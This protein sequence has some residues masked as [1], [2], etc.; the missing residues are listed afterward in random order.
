MVKERK[1]SVSMCVYGKD[2]PIWF[3]TAVESILNQTMKPAEVVLVV[4]G[5]VPNALDVVI[6]KYETSSLFK[7]VRFAENKGHGEARRAGLSVC[8]YDLVAIMDADDI[9]AHDR[10]EKQLLVFEQDPAVAIVGGII[11]EFV[12]EENNIVGKREIPKTDVEIKNYM[13][14]RCPMNLVTVMFKKDMIEQVGGF[15]DWYCE[16]DYYLWV[17]MALANMK[18]ANVSDV[19]VNVRVG[20]EMYQRRGGWKY[21]KS[22]AKLQKLMLSKKLIGVPKFFINVMERFILQVL[23]PN[24]LRGWV[25]QKFARKKA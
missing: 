16:E 23:M 5:P 4:D 24:R 1:F 14:D 10:F 20:K 17:R 8:S 25:F 12:G 21:F 6:R 19:L 3:E 2:N 22:E 15:I 9:S 7:V 11:T 18:F 13:K